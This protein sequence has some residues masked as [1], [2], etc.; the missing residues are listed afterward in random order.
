[1]RTVLAAGIQA[2]RL[3][4]SEN[5][6][7]DAEVLLCALLGFTDRSALILR[8][9]LPLTAEQ[10][11]DFQAAIARRARSEPLAYILGYRE[12]CS[13][14][15]EV[16]RHV[17]IPRP[18][19]ELMVEAVGRDFPE[20]RNFDSPGPPLRVLDMC[21]GSGCLGIS[22]AGECGRVELVLAD[23]SPEALAVCRRNAENILEKNTRWWAVQGDLFQALD[24]LPDQRPFDVIVANPPYIHP[25]EATALQ[26]D[27][28]DYEPA[29][30]L[31]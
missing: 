2:L 17:L 16:N 6:R 19:T 27:V 28:R 31:F 25:D 15:F 14:R 13:H 18:E 10:R 26:P 11:R 5:A 9:A 29:M 21:C 12:F 4:G 7:L 3:S 30:A 8:E 20:C 24:D 23:K 22:V 1:M